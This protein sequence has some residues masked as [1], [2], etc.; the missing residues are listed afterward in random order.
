MRKKKKKHKN[1]REQKR[2]SRAIVMPA[3]RASLGETPR[4]LKGTGI[5][6][7]PQEKARITAGE[8]EA[9]KHLLPRELPQKPCSTFQSNQDD[10]DCRSH[11]PDD[12]H[13]RRQ[14]RTSMQLQSECQRLSAIKQDQT[15]TAVGD[16]DKFSEAQAHGTNTVATRQLANESKTWI[17]VVG[18]IKNNSVTR[19]KFLRGDH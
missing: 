18:R 4:Q 10:Q 2:G 14:T 15:H 7:R 19:R 8:V 6:I 17:V 16:C 5:G 11:L 9:A 1:P 3:Q 13:T 12:R